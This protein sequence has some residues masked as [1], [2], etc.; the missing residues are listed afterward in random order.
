MKKQEWKK[1]LNREQCDLEPPCKMEETVQLCLD[2]MREQAVIQ[3]ERTGFWRYLSDILRYEGLGIFGLQ[4]ATLLAACL[5][6]TTFSEIPGILPSI[7]PLFALAAAPALFRA[8]FH[9][10]CEIEAATRSS[11]A[12]IVLAKLL[13]AG[14]ANLVCMTVLLCMEMLIQGSH[15][16]LGQMILYA[17]VPYLICMVLLLRLVRLRRRETLFTYTAATL[18]FSFIWGMIS[19]LIPWLYEASATGIWLIAFL[20]FTTFFVRELAYIITMRKEGKMYGIVS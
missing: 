4:A 10:M 5:W 20:L 2:I 3:E 19:N 17:L 6:V 15:E 7:M 12:Q 18:G 11:G 14:A 13:L 8:K 1:Y 16:A 9:G